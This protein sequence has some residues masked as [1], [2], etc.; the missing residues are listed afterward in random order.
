[1]S[2]ALPVLSLLVA[3]TTVSAAAPIAP[4]PQPPRDPGALTILAEIALE[5]G[6]CKGASEY[7]LEAVQQADASLAQRATSVALACEHLPAAWQAAQRLRTLSPQD[8]DAAAVYA[9][10]ALKLYRIS[11]AQA[12]IRV[13]LQGADREP[14]LAELTSLLLDGAE[15][16]AVLGAI[17]GAVDEA[18]ASPAVLTLLS[19]LALNGYDF[20]RSERYAQKALEKDPKIFEAQSLLSQVYAKQGD[21][22]KALAAAKAASELD[23]KRGTFETA[24]AL[25]T[26]DRAA[27]A[28]EE[29]E[30]IRASNEGFSAE[31]DRRLAL[32]ALQGNDFEEARKRFLALATAPNGA[33]T[34]MFYLAELDALQG[35]QEKALAGYRRLLGTSVGPTARTRA[36]ELLLERGSRGEALKLLD[37]YAADHPESAFELTMTKAH[38]LADHGE[39]DSGLALVAAALGEHP[40]HPTLEYDRAVLLESAGKVR[41][42]VHALEQL[43]EERPEDPTVLNALGYTLADH[44]M[45]LPYAESLIRR[46]LAVTPDNPAVVDSL[47]WVRFKRGD[48]RGAAKLLARAYALSRDSEIAAHWGEALWKSGD[49]AQARQV[50]SSALAL[51]PDSK[52]L[53]TVIGRFIPVKKP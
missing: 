53:Q 12:A 5:R 45:R 4:E 16:P 34:A 38:L 41:E 20:G 14:R 33:D 25:I 40:K 10:V 37:D 42:S 27:E 8:A 39:P 43:L 36:A 18:T 19:E 26:L 17:S 50:W 7:Y 22:A 28:R 48:S 46:A 3:A 23:A 11:D 47:G 51:D 35:D 2:N 1:M 49:K 29:L 31:V 13:V 15:A 9:A 52:A 32:L 6:D 24:Q 30:R 44:G 21:A